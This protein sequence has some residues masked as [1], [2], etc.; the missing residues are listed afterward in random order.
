MS[1]ELPSS[2][3]PASPVVPLLVPPTPRSEERK[4]CGTNEN[5]LQRLP[6]SKK[7]FRCAVESDYFLFFH[8]KRAL[9]FI[10]PFFDRY[11]D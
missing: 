6:A 10:Q 8:G 9:A 5:P 2:N 3:P 1:L 11:P 4:V 7:V